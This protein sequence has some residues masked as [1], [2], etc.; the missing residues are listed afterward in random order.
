M[1]IFLRRGFGMFSMGKAGE[2]VTEKAEA[3][4]GWLFPVEDEADELGYLHMFTDMFD[5]IDQGRPPQET[6]Y[7][8]Y[9]INAIFDVVC[10]SAASKHWEA[11][12]LHVRRGAEA[13]EAIKGYTSCDDKYYLIKEEVLPDGVT[14]RILKDV[15]NGQVVSMEVE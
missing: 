14:K 10:R 8:G 13:S 6:L 2:Y 4:R 9:V 15:Q 5:S 3:N 1:N 7:D 11:V 12:G